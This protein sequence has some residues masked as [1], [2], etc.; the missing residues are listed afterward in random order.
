MKQETR[1]AK[2]LDLWGDDEEV[3]EVLKESLPKGAQEQIDLDIA[4]YEA[5]AAL[6]YVGSYEDFYQSTCV[7]CE[8]PFAA[9]Y[10]RISTCSNRCLK[11]AVEAMGFTWDP[12]R[13]VVDRFRPKEYNFPPERR[14]G[15]T[16]P[17]YQSRVQIWKDRQ[18]AWRPVPLTVPSEVVE[19]LDQLGIVPLEKVPHRPA[20]LRN[21]VGALIHQT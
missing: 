20:I 18:R 12:T 3:V 10:P 15:E 21:R 9:S 2:L 19:L 4:T 7:A 13:S 14:K 8:K 6:I 11:K 5:E 1:R 17:I 16:L